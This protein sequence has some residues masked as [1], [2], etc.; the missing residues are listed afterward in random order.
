MDEG[1][2]QWALAVELGVGKGGGGL[3][4]GK[5]HGQLLTDLAH[6]HLVTEAHQNSQ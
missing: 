5:G 1:P 3:C 2:R 6:N 4:S